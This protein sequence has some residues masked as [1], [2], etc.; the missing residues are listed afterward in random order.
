MQRK[1][2]IKKWAL[3]F[4][5]S[6]FLLSYVNKALFTHTHLLPDGRVVVHAHP[7][8]KHKNNH[9]D[10]NLPVQSHHHTNQQ[11]YYLSIHYIY[12]SSFHYL[13]IT[14]PYVSSEVFFPEGTYVFFPETIHLI[15]VRAPP[16]I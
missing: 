1:I 3:V 11:Y 10:K 4:V 14:V 12:Y 5:G 8:L 6:I 9:R 15:S 16:L 7:Y 13:R 2:T